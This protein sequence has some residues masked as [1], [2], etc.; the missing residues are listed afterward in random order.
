L[1]NCSTKRRT[2]TSSVV[3][4][5]KD[6][7]AFSLDGAAHFPIRPESFVSVRPEL[8]EDTLLPVND[9]SDFFAH[10]GSA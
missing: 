2:A 3:I 10:A 5:L 6:R 7:V 9:N 8:V 4:S 1:W